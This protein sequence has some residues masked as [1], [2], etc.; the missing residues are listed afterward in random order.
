MV[1]INMVESAR[2][3]L[4]ISCAYFEIVWMIILDENYL[5]KNVF[6]NKITKTKMQ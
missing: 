3:S 4:Y 5:M 6:C 2:F 1:K